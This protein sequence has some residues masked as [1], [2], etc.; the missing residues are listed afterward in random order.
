V[1]E[2]VLSALEALP[3]ALR[4]R[5]SWFE[6][7]DAWSLDD[8]L[9][10]AGRVAA[11]LRSCGAG[12]SGLGV[13]AG[14]TGAA[15]FAGG[16]GV[17]LAGLAAMLA[18]PEGGDASGARVRV[19]RSLAVESAAA[20]D[21]PS[22]PAETAW[23]RTTG[24]TTGRPR[25]VAFTEA[26]SLA[27]ARASIALLGL[28]EG[29]AVATTVPPWTAFG[30]NSGA[31]VPMLACAEVR[32]VPS[33][34]PR[35]LVAEARRA[36]WVVTTPPV[37]RALARLRLARSGGDAPTRLLVAGSAYP[38]AEARAL[39]GV[40]LLV[41]DRYGATEVGPIAQARE[42]F[43]ALF[44]APGVT[45]RTAGDP[46]TLEVSGPGVAIGYAGEAERRFGGSFRTPDVVDLRAD[47]SFRVVARADRAV[48]RMGR[49]V[50]LAH[51]ER[52]VASAPGVALAR[53][54]AVPGALDVDV[55]AEAVPERG[56]DLD[57]GLVLRWARER[58]DPWERPSR[59]EVVPPLP[60]GHQAQWT[61]RGGARA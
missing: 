36:D 60:A 13:V 19:D 32:A 33:A 27:G 23:V 57:A 43:G 53:V 38:D 40:G 7:G 22:L 49:V 14:E 58:L 16:L 35:G 4:A 12:P 46:A 51:V 59:V 24:G 21:A 30:W 48:K 3:P 61:P 44:A 31:V 6:A 56:R 8:L 41:I 25:L 52:Q 50:D 45:V 15:A 20:G 17:R 28:A 37:V 18:L 55:V 29:D 39:E 47:G 10:A 54:R 11:A 2:S 26:Q 1:T 5:P 9:L 34:S 42:P